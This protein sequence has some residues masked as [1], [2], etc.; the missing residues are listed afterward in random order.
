MLTTPQTNHEE[1]LLLS[2]NDVCRLTG[3]SLSTVK[4]K[5]ESGELPAFKVTSKAIR[6]RRSDV[7]AWVENLSSVEVI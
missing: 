6:L 7:V 5:I 4:R 3:L 1:P 2:I